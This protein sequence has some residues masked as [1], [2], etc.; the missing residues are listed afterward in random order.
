MKSAILTTAFAL[1]SFCAM[2]QISE[3]NGVD[4]VTGATRQAKKMEQSTDSQSRLYLG[5]YGEAVMTRNFYMSGQMC[6][7][8][9]TGRGIPRRH[10]HLS[11]SWSM[12]SHCTN[13]LLGLSKS[14]SVTIST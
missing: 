11:P 8:V 7:G 9:I 6:H 10:G 14:L 13:R 5:G 3:D 1:Y 12:S 2:A 4:A